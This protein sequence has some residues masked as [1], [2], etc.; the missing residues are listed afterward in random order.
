MGETVQVEGLPQLQASLD[1]LAQQLPQLAPPE[2]VRLVGA[3]AQR[4]APKRTGRLAGS[5]AGES[6]PGRNALTFG[7][8][9]AN[10]IHWGVG[11]RAGLRG[12]H[13]IRPSHFLIDAVNQLQPQWLQAYSD[14]CQV[15]VD[16]V[17]GA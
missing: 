14:Q 5:F 8:V 13:N 17:K 4:R 16:K 2:A 15:L 1:R 7:V 12:P 11:S 3:E 10:A 9:Y 6:T